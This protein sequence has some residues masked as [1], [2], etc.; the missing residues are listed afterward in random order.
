MPKRLSDFKKSLYEKHGLKVGVSY[1]SLYMRTS[2]S[3]TDTDSGWGGW[4]QFN[5]AWSAINRGKDWQGRLVLVLDGRHIVNPSSHTAPGLLSID[6]GSL[7]PH[8]GAYLEWGIYPLSLFWEQRVRKDKFAFRV[9][10]QVSLAVIDPFRFDEMKS[11]FTSAAIAGSLAVIPAG[12]PGLG[13]SAK[14]WPITGSDLYLSGI[15]SDIN[16]PDGEL[17]WSGVFDHGEVF[18]ASEIGYFWLRKEDDFDHVHLT[19]WYADE[20][21]TAAWDTKAGWGFKLSGNKQWGRFVA[22]G[23]Y[24]YNTAEGGGLGITNQRQAVSAGAAHVHPLGIRG[25]LALGVSW[26]DPIDDGLR[27]QS[28]LEV[29]WK[30]LVTPNLWLTPGFQYIVDPTFNP[31]TDSFSIAQLKFSLFF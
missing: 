17:D 23:D 18:A 16:S 28:G 1:Q 8:D 11:S 19:L 7:W 13:V 9:G 2:D 30:L 12:A 21:S 5:S 14:W 4:F 10:Q 20:V 29:Y 6:T 24:A 31:E 15:V 22:F 27:R 3:L 25:E 26:G